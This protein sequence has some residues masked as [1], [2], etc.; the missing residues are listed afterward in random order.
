MIPN[1][2]EIID[3][4]KML[5]YN[6]D[7]IILNTEVVIGRVDIAVSIINKILAQKQ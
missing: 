1:P 3:V 4:T 7:G 2:A 5:E 6:P